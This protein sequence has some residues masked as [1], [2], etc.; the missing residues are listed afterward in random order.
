MRQ[1]NYFHRGA[2]TK[3]RFALLLLAI[4]GVTY[5]G[6]ESFY[7]RANNQQQDAAVAVMA[8]PC[9]LDSKA[10]NNGP[11]AC[12][13]GQ[14]AQPIQKNLPDSVVSRPI[15]D[16]KVIAPLPDFTYAAKIA[17]QAVVHVKVRKCSKVKYM[18]SPLDEFFREFFGE[19]FGTPRREYEVPEQYATGSGVIY[20]ESGYIVTN[21]HVIEGADHIEVTLHDNR[22]YTAKLIGADATTDLALLKVQETNLPFLQL[23]NSDTL[24]V[25]EWVLAVGN[26]FNLHSTVTKGIVSAKSR[27]LGDNLGQKGD[28]RFTIQSFIQTDA[29]I[30][31]GN[32]GG[33][34]VNLYGQLVGINSAIYAN[35]AVSFM[36]YGF[37]IPVSLVKKVVNDLMQYG[38][39]QRV[40][41]GVTI[42]EVNAEL[43]KKLGL[44]KVAGVYIQ[45]VA[46]TSP[47]VK[48]LQKEDVIT[49]INDHKIN[50]VAELQEII[51]CS[52]P[53]DKITITLFRKGKEKTIAVVLE[54]A[55]DPVQ[56]VQKGTLLQVE[57]ASFNDLEEGIKKKLKL[58][59]GI[60]VVE[61]GKG[62]FQSAGLKK[63]YI[64]TAFDKKPVHNIKAFAEMVRNAKEA[65]LL[66]VIDPAK[67]TVSYLAIDFVNQRNIR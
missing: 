8:S 3:G 30:N 16:K 13:V 28:P 31:Q 43:A 20:T 26:P 35:S 61:V 52:K 6:V 49:Q 33:A 48:L 46:Q 57:D 25:G 23:G 27:Q 24:E 15:E 42:S 2:S 21:N 37:A 64:V 59:A 54:K 38:A 45:N 19:R 18:T 50:K 39:V 17:T 1:Y 67:R 7:L 53:G 55:P 34:L 29:A 62:K 10:A 44:S 58:S 22:C 4:G 14:E 47:C 40:M 51:A 11:H 63:G 32:S 9:T 65:A 12:S 41:L 5:L 60:L 56:V 36:G 66:E